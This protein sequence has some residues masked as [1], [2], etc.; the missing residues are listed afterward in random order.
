MFNLKARDEAYTRRLAE[1]I[2]RAYAL[3]V[4]SMQAAPRGWYGETWSVQTGQGRFFCKIITHPTHGANYRRSFAAL[5][6]MH[7]MGIDFVSQA[8]Q[9]L[10]GDWHLAFEEGTLGLFRHVEGVHTEDYP[11]EQLFG[12]LAQ[13]YRLPVEEFQV[14][15][16]DFSCGIIEETWGYLRQAEQADAKGREL[17]GLI[18]QGGDLQRC[19][20]VLQLSAAKCRC[21]AGGLVV[22][23]G[24]VGGNVI[25]QGDKMTI[26]DWDD[27]RLAPIERDL[28]YY[29]WEEGQRELIDRVLEQSGTGRQLN[30]QRLV[31]SCM[32]MHFFYMCEYMRCFLYAPEAWESLLPAVEE[33][34]SD[35]S[36]TKRCRDKAMDMARGWERV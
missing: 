13:I 19:A 27:I 26:I 3:D 30:A 14:P 34:V 32:R 15:A 11:L 9:T 28:W 12:H 1:C 6:T 2:A 36:W 8:V 10:W 21:D 29:M 24:D 22:T 23:S 31:F 20:R 17:A 33:H 4:D 18:K 35:A 5:N 16:E 7:N 25:M